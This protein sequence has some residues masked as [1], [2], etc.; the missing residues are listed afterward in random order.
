MS[1]TRWLLLASGIGI[2]AVFG[3]LAAPKL[4]Y[5]D[6][7][8]AFAV[9]GDYFS[10]LEE[11]R[12]G[13]A[14]DLFTEKFLQKEGQDW[15][16]TIADLD[17]NAG[18]VTGFEPQSSMLAPVTLQDGSEVSC[19]LIRYKVS[20]TKLVS[21]ETLTI[22][23]HQRGDDWGIAGHEITRSDTGERYEAGLTIR[24]KKILSTN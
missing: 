15:Q 4:H 11:N 3:V 6:Q 9:G 12:R 16:K 19:V 7:K 13:E 17:A 20:R 5:I 8:P 1:A 14:F 24:E 10:K 21:D 2:I 22:C 18:E 23:P